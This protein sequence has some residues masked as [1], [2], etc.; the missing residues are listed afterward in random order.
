MPHT[1]LMGGGCSKDFCIVARNL[2][3]QTQVP[4]PPRSERRSAALLAPRCLFVRAPS[5]SQQQADDALL[6]RA[7][8]GSPCGCA[9]SSQ[10]AQHSEQGCDRRTG[11]EELLPARCCAAIASAAKAV[12][13]SSTPHPVC[14]HKARQR[15]HTQRAHR[16]DVET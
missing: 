16:R 3:E 12:N 6:F 10:R 7:R 9:C 1:K 11:D 8:R 13:A 5:V 2:A 4:A 15:C 14:E